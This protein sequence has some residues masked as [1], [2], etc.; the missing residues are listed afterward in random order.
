M[1]A[2]RT[3]NE[4]LALDSLP[5][6][7]AV[8]ALA[9]VVTRDGRVANYELLQSV[10]ASVRRRR[11]A[12]Q[13]DEVSA[14]LDAVKDSR[15][16]PAQTAAGAVA[17]NMVWVLARTTVK[18]SFRPDDPESLPSL[19]APGDTAKTASADLVRAVPRRARS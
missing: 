15:F 4:G 19:S 8:F 14:L 6:D 16:T 10:R 1:L 3:V 11:A 9:A 5:E 12:A 7:E 2:P 13:S 17:V 18:A